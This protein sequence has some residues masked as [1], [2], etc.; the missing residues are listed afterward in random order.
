[1]NTRAAETPAP[2][3]PVSAGVLTN[4][5]L[6]PVQIPKSVFTYDETFGK[7]PFNPKSTRR[8]QPEEPE[9]IETPDAPK[10][11]PK[12]MSL[13]MNPK[14]V[15]RTVNTD[16]TG[17]DFLSIKGIIATARSRT[18]TLDTTTRTYSFRSG[19][20]YFVRVPDNGRLRIRCVEIRSREAV[21]KL[22]D[23]PEPIVLKMR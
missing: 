15:D 23:R 12:K 6:I 9:V 4:A 17:L 22:S 3:A 19:D 18:V 13:Q 21:F 20:E 1:V 2:S 7:D 10:P 14:L 8:T 16:D 11:E 5:A